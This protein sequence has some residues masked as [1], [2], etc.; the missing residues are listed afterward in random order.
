MR[1]CTEPGFPKG[2]I[3]RPK[4]RTHGTKCWYGEND[5]FSKLLVER[6][7]L[8]GQ[9]SIT[10]KGMLNPGKERGV[11]FI[12]E[13]EGVRRERVDCSREKP[14]SVDVGKESELEVKFLKNRP[15]DA[16]GGEKKER[17]RPDDGEG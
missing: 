14:L 6:K 5:D 16:G 10:G 3:F 1:E 9:I 13:E 12:G 15:F 11:G 4:K 8:R 17:L 7:S 2:E